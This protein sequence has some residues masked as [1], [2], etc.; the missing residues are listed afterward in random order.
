MIEVEWKKNKRPF[1]GTKTEMMKTFSL[2]YGK[3][4]L[5]LKLPRYDLQIYNYV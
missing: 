5:F 4:N 1:S 2:A 3:C